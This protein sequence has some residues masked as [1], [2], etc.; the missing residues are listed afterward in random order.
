M[1]IV[2][3]S[4]VVGVGVVLI[5]DNRLLLVQRG[6][7]PSRGLWAVPGGK[8]NPG[9]SLRDAA[10]R[11]VLEETGLEVEIGEVVWVGEHIFEHGHIVIIDFEGHVVG[12][13]LAAA[14]DAEQARWV[15]LTQVADYD[16]TPTM[17]DLVEVLQKST[18]R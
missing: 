17:Y 6:H 7:E 2:S 9:E 16:L 11:E 3:D 12:G 10:A 4:P 18:T 8:V 15:G 14:D 13:E 5:D 1:T